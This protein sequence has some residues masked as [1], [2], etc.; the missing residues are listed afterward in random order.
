MAIN[1]F[2]RSAFIGNSRYFSS[3][4][5]NQSQ[6]KR[7]CK[8]EQSVNQTKRHQTRIE[9]AR[10]RALNGIGARSAPVE[11]FE[12]ARHFGASPKCRS[13]A[14]P[15]SVDDMVGQMARSWR[16]RDP[17]ESSHETAF[18]GILFQGSFH[19]FNLRDFGA[20][21]S[22]RTARYSREFPQSFSWVPQRIAGPVSWSMGPVPT[23]LEAHLRSHEAA[24]DESVRDHS[25]M[26][27]LLSR[28]W[29]GLRAR[30]SFYRGAQ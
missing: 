20:S 24:R 2:S 22:F 28:C 8:E 7:S 14:S 23:G 4:L 15:H 29:S 26:E 11:I 13:V 19:K 12:S 27:T 18:G 6:P 5:Q 17:S 25:R 30:S 16:Q 3:R 9:M 21:P 10:V 1:A